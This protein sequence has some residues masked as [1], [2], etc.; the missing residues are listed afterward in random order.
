MSNSIIERMLILLRRDVAI[1]KGSKRHEHVVAERLK[2]VTHRLAA[3]W[4]LQLDALLT[5]NSQLREAIKESLNQQQGSV[6]A[7]RRRVVGRSASSRISLKPRVPKRQQRAKR[8]RLGRG[9][10]PLGSWV[11]RKCRNVNYPN[12]IFC[13]LTSCSSRR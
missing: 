2:D 1:G 9:G 10:Y 5:S 7:G 12:R 3:E 8:P 6:Q 13:N 11:C 4:K